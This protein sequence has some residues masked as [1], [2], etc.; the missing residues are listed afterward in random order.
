MIRTLTGHDIPFALALCRKAGWNQLQAD[1]LRLFAYEPDGCFVAELDGQ[2]VGTVTTTRYGTDLAWIGMML[3]DD[4]YRR[5]GIATSLMNAS[6]SYLR[7]IGV[8]CIKLD[9]T[10]EG[11]LV[12]ERLGFQPE[13][14][15]HR[16]SRNGETSPRLSPSRPSDQL[17]KSH[18]QLDQTAF[19]TDRSAWLMQLARSLGFEPVRDLTRMR[20]GSMPTSPEMK[21]QF[22]LTDPG[23][24]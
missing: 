18:L 16:W 5:R 12:Y 20:I 14:S 15:F 22:A 23:T 13:G 3:V 4:R 21:F 6:L 19:A 2:I 7:D 9:A 11:Q 17:V 24:G 1:W 8:G 10:P